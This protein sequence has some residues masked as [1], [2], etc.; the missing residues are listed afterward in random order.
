MISMAGVGRPPKHV[1]PVKSPMQQWSFYFVGRTQDGKKYMLVNRDGVCLF[2]SEDKFK[3][4]IRDN[5]VYGCEVVK[6]VYNV[7]MATPA[8][9]SCPCGMSLSSAKYVDVAKDVRTGKETKVQGTVYFNYNAAE[10]GIYIF[11][12]E[13][14]RALAAKKLGCTPTSV[15]LA[16]ADGYE[17]SKRVLSANKMTINDIGIRC[18]KCGSLQHHHWR[19]PEYMQGTL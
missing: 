12:V 4:L 6:G 8:C 16:Y 15:K 9:I 5:K 2:A 3:M 14:H 10:N 18:K 17:P 7:S 13:A 19:Q 11:N 1:E